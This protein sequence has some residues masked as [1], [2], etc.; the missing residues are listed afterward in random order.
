MYTLFYTHAYQ[1]QC[2]SVGDCDMAICGGVNCLFEPNVFVALCKAR[3]LS[4]H[5]QCQTFTKHADGYARGEGC[6][7][8]ILKRMDK[9]RVGLNVS[10]LYML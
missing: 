10:V 1:L 6:G 2:I 9:V 7:I 4:P 8:V 5:G 3:M